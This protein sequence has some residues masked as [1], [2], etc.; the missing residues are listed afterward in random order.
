MNKTAGYEKFEHL[1]DKSNVLLYML[2]E[3]ADALTELRNNVE[4]LRL[5][6]KELK[7]QNRRLASRVELMEEKKDII[8]TRAGELL[9]ALDDAHLL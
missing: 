1:T 6:N 8:D 5:E 4:L 9:G 3:E 7:K 2:K